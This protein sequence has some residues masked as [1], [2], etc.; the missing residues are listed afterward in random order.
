MIEQFFTHTTLES[1]IFTHEE[2]TV[3][4]QD[5]SE[6]K[7]NQSD[8]V[9]RI[10]IQCAI[11]HGEVQL[12]NFCARCVCRLNLRSDSFRNSSIWSTSHFSIGYSIIKS[13]HK[14]GHEVT[15]ISP[16]PQKKPLENYRDISTKD[17]LD[18]HEKGKEKLEEC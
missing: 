3:N 4:D 9:S 8:G 1:F 17:I 11:N 15:V 13:L 10:F 18:K 14:V 7:R 5:T 2:S 6:H 12:F 16:Y